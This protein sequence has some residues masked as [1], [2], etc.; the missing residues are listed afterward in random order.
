MPSKSGEIS[1]ELLLQDSAIFQ[2]KHVSSY[3]KTANMIFDKHHQ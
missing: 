2:R 1:L 3:M